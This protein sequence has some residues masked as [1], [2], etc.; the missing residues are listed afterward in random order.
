MVVIT[1]GITSTS[2]PLLVL[3]PG[4][5]CEVGLGLCRS[6]LITV[7]EALRSTPDPKNSSSIT[8]T[9]RVLRLLLNYLAQDQ[10]EMGRGR[11]DEASQKKVSDMNLD[12]DG[13][14][15]RLDL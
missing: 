14:G 9:R 11:W 7:L 13:N 8:N 3:H 5:S 1:D 10:G 2:S 12:F 15:K 4:T 6:I